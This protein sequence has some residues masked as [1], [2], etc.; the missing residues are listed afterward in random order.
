MAQ[1][2]RTPVHFP[3]MKVRGR[4]NK[5]KLAARHKHVVFVPHARVERVAT[6]IRLVVLSMAELGSVAFTVTQVFDGFGRVL[7]S[8]A[9]GRIE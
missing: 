3:K 1:I 5:A 4:R 9:Q 7:R 6:G 8:E 2:P